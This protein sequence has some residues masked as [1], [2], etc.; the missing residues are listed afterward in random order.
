MSAPL[1]D[2]LQQVLQGEP[3]LGDEVDAV[4]RRADRLRRLRTRALLGAGAAAVAVIAAAG[5]LLA[6][7]LLPGIT[8]IVAASAP[9]A[10]APSAVPPSSTADPVRSVLLP[11][12]D[13]KDLTIADGAEERG[14][15][16]RSYPVR[17][18]DG[19]S[20]G[21]VAVAV[22]HVAADLCF[23]VRDAPDDCAHT[24]W[25]PRGIEFVRYDDEKDADRQVHETIAR[26]ISDGR[27]LA[28][29]ATGERGAGGSRGKPALSGKQIEK[30]ATDPRLF[31]AFDATEHCPVPS[32]A[33]CPVFRVPVPDKKQPPAGE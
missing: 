28:V 9:P 12:I 22:Y 32:G 15:G 4:F 17:D 20:R 33:A 27:T 18:S 6:V 31:D 16:W 1:S 23:P 5:Y 14:G 19:R 2:L 3:E 30:V 25:A 10:A 24:E 29:M 7:T 11:P 26:R 21:T 13:G 8:P